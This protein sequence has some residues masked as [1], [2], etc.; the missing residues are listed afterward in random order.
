MTARGEV[1]AAK[2]LAR[3]LCREYSIVLNSSYIPLPVSRVVLDLPRM[4][5]KPFTVPL[6]PDIRAARLTNSSSGW[7]RTVSRLAFGD[8]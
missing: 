5:D 8:R 7:R 3:T 1:I 2:E 6:P 4:W